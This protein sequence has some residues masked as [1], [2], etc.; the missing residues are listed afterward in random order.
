MLTADLSQNCGT[1]IYKEGDGPFQGTVV[2][3]AGTL[4][5]GG[6]EGVKVG[7]ELWVKQRAGWVKGLE[8]VAQ[9][10]EFA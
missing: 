3:Q 2:V 5:E 7:A 10:Q 4:D 6:L 9:L 8:G 1:T